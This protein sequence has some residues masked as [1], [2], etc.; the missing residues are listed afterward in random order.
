MG[1][2]GGGGGWAG[3]RVGGSKRETEKE[4]GVAVSIA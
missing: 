3:G 1:V 2:G 4:K